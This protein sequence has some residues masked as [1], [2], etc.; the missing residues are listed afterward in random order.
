MFTVKVVINT[1]KIHTLPARDFLSSS[2]IYRKFL[3][4]KTDSSMWNHFFTQRKLHKKSVHFQNDCADDDTIF[5]LNNITRI[6]KL[7]SLHDSFQD[8]PENKIWPLL[9]EFVWNYQSLLHNK[10]HYWKMTVIYGYYTNKR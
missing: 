6:L 1:P 9:C 4:C 7:H 8:D 5:L 3:V 2:L 10:T